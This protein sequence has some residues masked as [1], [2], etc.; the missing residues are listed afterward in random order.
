MKTLKPPAFSRIFVTFV[1]LARALW[2]GAWTSGTSDGGSTAG[3]DDVGDV[4]DIAGA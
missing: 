3:R 2:G 4:G 1:G